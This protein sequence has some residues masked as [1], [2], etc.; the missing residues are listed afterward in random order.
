MVKIKLCRGGKMRNDFHSFY[1]YIED[2]REKRFKLHSFD[3]LTFTNEAFRII[4][5]R[6]WA[7]DYLDVIKSGSRYKGLQAIL[8][9]TKTKDGLEALDT[10]MKRAGKYP[11]RGSLVAGQPTNKRLFDYAL[12]ISDGRYSI[13]LNKPHGL[14]FVETHLCRGSW[15]C[16]QF[17]K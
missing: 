3:C 14:T 9:H 13:F 8:A 15:V 6:G 7:D 1:Q 12:G 16:P 11:E 5:G 4:H 10:I 17:F 2:V